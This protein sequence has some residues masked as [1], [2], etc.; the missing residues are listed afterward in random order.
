LKKSCII[1][2]V[3]FLLTIMDLAFTV[4]GLQLGI[5]E[6]AN[7]IMRYFLNLSMG[8]SI[9]CVLLFMGTI[10]IFLYKASY[11]LHWLHPAMTGLA[12][13]KVYVL[14]L[15]LRWISIYLS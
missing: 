14:L 10:L 11:K 12:G 15:H 8:F 13:I 4:T 2:Y 6:E 9:L 1:F 5:I 7:P 3:I